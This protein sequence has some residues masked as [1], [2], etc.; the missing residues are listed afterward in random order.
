MYLSI[1]PSESVF[2]LLA[3]AILNFAM[4]RIFISFILLVATS[5]PVFAGATTEIVEVDTEC[6]SELNK[7]KYQLAECQGRNEQ[8]ESKLA[9]LQ[10]KH[11]ALATKNT[12]AAAKLEALQAKIDERGKLV[13][14]LKSELAATQ[15]D[16]ANERNKVPVQTSCEE[17]NSDDCDG[18][19]IAPFI[20]APVGGVVGLV[21]GAGSTAADFSSA[22][23]N[24]MGGGVVS[25]LVAAPTAGVVGLATGAVGGLLK[26]VYLGVK[27]GLCDPWHS[28]TISIHR[29]FADYNT[30][31]FND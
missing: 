30:F 6:Q 23:A 10:L 20:T 15:Q 14:Q 29:E 13:A 11:D 3:F 19:L 27:Y 5:A 25:H 2:L 22:M 24:S 18:N 16:L 17:N 9:A 12:A 8:L 31:D 4:L 7:L 1:N 28:K 26:G 21:R